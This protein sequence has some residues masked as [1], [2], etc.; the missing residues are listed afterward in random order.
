MNY[1][2]SAIHSTTILENAVESH[3]YSSELKQFKSLLNKLLLL[4]SYID[5]E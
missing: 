3:H 5:L 2:N 1:L 4:I